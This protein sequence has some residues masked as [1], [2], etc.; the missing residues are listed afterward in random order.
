M[1]RMRFLFVFPVRCHAKR[2]ICLV[3]HTIF[4]ACYYIRTRK[5]IY[6]FSR[7][8]PESHDQQRNS[9]H[10][11]INV[12]SDLPAENTPWEN[13]S[14]Q[15]I[16]SMLECFRDKVLT[17]NCNPQTILVFLS[18]RWTLAGKRRVVWRLLWIVGNRIF[19]LQGT[20]ILFGNLFESLLPT[21]VMIE[22]VFSQ[23]LCYLWSYSD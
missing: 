21:F 22:A 5:E 18:W 17:T 23:I 20:R 10:K 8:E 19:L 12:S 11:A 1:L 15:L 2:K 16:W 3:E 7:K 13:D 14:W 9:K 4:G 6:L